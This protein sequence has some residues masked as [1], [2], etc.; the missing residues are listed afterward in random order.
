MKTWLLFLAAPIVWFAHFSALYG[1]A[2]FANLSST[3]AW[4]L[5]GLAGL[6]VASVWFAARRSAGGMTAWLALL[7]LAGILFQGLPLALMP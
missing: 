1:I 6:A 3:V 4:T 5:T 7:C 2:S